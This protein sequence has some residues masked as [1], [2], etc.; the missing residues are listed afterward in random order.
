MPI[1]DTV[2]FT[3]PSFFAFLPSSISRPSLLFY[4]YLEQ[5][6]SRKG[7]QKDNL[8][9]SNDVDDTLDLFFQA[10]S[11]FANTEQLAVMAATLANNGVCPV[12]KKYFSRQ[13]SQGITR[14]T[15]SFTFTDKQ[16]LPMQ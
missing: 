6:L 4:E 10:K 14:I 9:L 5:K 11:I 1:H 3:F 13:I 12:T 2:F 7:D 8:P 16:Y 15:N